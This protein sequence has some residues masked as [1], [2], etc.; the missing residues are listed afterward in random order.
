VEAYIELAHA[1]AR[2]G[3]Y[4]AAERALKKGLEQVPE[5]YT[6]LRALG[7]LEMATQQYD[8]SVDAYKRA[9]DRYPDSVDA[10]MNLATAYNTRAA[11]LVRR[12]DSSSAA[13]DLRRILELDIDS[14]LKRTVREQ[15]E[16]LDVGKPAAQ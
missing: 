2:T 7:R 13:A 3:D 16:Q 10:R 5:D 15:L 8:R 6:L 9:A 11:V 4:D 12:G 14:T 1:E